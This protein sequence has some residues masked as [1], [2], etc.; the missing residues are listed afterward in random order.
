MAAIKNGPDKYPGAKNVFKKDEGK[1]F[2]LGF[3]NRDLDIQEGDIVHRHLVDGDV[4]LFNRQ[5]SLHKA[6]MMCHR[7]RV[8]PYSTFRLNVSATKPFNADFDGD[9]MNMHVP[10]S[11]AAATELRIIATLLRQIVSPRTCQPIISVFQ[12]TLTGAYRISQ[13]DVTIPEHIAMNILA[14]SPRGISEF[15]RMDMPM[16]GTDVVSHAFPLMYFNG[17]VQI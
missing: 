12:D 6:S 10:Q 2:R 9:E 16:A 7:V 14:R 3:V 15:K 13:P 17:N 5:P 4:V 8:L 11:I 1:A